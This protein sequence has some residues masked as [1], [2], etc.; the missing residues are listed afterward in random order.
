MPETVRIMSS[1]I[2]G[3]CPAHIRISN[4]D[5]LLDVLYRRYLPDAVGMQEVSPKVRAEETDIFD[6]TAPLYRELA[7]TP[8][9]EGNN[10]TPILYRPGRLAAEDSGFFRYAGPNDG[11]SKSLTW[12]L[13]RTLQGSRFFL[14]NTH[15][16]YTVDD[17]GRAARVSNSFEVLALVTRL[18]QKYPDVPFIFTGD[19]NCLTG[20]AP[21]SLLERYDICDTCRLA[22]DPPKVSSW[23]DYPVMN[24]DGTFSIPSAICPD[25]SKTLDHILVRGA[26]TVQALSVVTDKEAC[27]ATD[28]SPVYADLSL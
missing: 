1:N 19:F 12:G 13:F 8:V 21:L 22:A 6:L 24:E 3:N 14:L 25:P 17:T 26:V 7:V 18:A 16:Y 23:H 15:Y 10:Y 27:I 9:P 11:G 28:H 4:R 2:W 5:D 20:D